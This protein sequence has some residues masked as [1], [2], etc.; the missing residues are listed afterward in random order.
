MTAVMSA[1]ATRATAGFDPLPSRSRARALALA[2]A[3]EV[4]ADA[5]SLGIPVASSG[6]VPSAVGVDRELLLESGFT[7]AVGQALPLPRGQHPLIVAVG[8]GEPGSLE[9]AGLRDAAAA[10]AR[11][12]VRDGRLAT[13]LGDI[14]DLDPASAGQAIA[15]GVLLARYR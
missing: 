10:F 4:P 15:E 11:A 1:D 2:T 3:T 5:E 14:P 9:T 13:T 7:G 8:I 12:A 6:D